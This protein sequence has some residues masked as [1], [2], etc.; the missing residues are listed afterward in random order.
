V[1]V[2]VTMNPSL[3]R[4]MEIARLDRGSL[5]RA[6]RTRADPGGKG[7]N[8]ARALAAH[9]VPTCAVVPHCGPDGE[10]LTTLLGLEGID[11]CAV[12]VTGRTRST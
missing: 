1:I 6:D 5:H 9:G 4:T 11:V 3:D 8:V 12:P 2:T 10:R 7:V